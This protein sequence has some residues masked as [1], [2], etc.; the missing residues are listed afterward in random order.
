MQQLPERFPG[1]LIDSPNGC[2]QHVA[3]FM[4]DFQFHCRAWSKCGFWVLVIMPEHTSG[5]VKLQWG[6]GLVANVSPFASLRLGAFAKIPS[7]HD[8]GFCQ[9]PPGSIRGWHRSISPSDDRGE[10]RWGPI[11]LWLSLHVKVRAPRR[12]AAKAQRKRGGSDYGALTCKEALSVLSICACSS[13]RWACVMAS[14]SCRSADAM[15]ASI[16]PRCCRAKARA[17]SGAG[18]S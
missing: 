3:F 1:G 10:N 16:S 12:Q 6:R 9:Q 17:S 11:V 18:G 4:G 15:R 7:R 2:G 14:M 13:C 5:T 8:V